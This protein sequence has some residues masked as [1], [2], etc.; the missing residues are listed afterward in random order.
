MNKYIHVFMDDPML[1][2]RF[3]WFFM[4]RSPNAG[5]ARPCGSHR[6]TGL[7]ESGLAPTTIE[8]LNEEQLRELLLNRRR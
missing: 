6:G 7:A 8:Y 4:I 2:L 5:R 1:V 3:F